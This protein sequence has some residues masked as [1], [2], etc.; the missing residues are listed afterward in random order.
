MVVKKGLF[1]LGWVLSGRKPGPTKAKFQINEQFTDANEADGERVLGLRHEIPDP[2][3][4]WR[5]HDGGWQRWSVLD[6]EF[7][8]VPAPAALVALVAERGGPADDEVLVLD[9]GEWRVEEP[10]ERDAREG[11]HDP[12][13]L[14]PPDDL[15]QP[16]SPAPPEA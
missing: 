6:A 8:A 9:A 7:R 12:I 10:G 4:T 11:R 13:D 3:P 16:A 5:S 14:G 2:L 15:G 1:G